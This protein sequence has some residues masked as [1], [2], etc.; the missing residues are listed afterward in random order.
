MTR[1]IELL[2]KINSDLFKY[3]LNEFN[4]SEKNEIYLQKLD[5]IASNFINFYSIFYNIEAHFYNISTKNVKNDKNKLKKY[6]LFRLF[7]NHFAEFNATLENISENTI[8][9]SNYLTNTLLNLVEFNNIYLNIYE[10]IP[11]CSLDLE[12][13]SDILYNFS[14]AFNRTLEEDY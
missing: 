6:Q 4:K 12:A 9:I 7:L 1:K 3:I 2:A 13:F 14:E 5:K 10:F 8:N 11:T